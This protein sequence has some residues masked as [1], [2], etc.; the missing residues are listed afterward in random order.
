MDAVRPLA[1]DLCAQTGTRCVDLLVS[2]ATNAFAHPYAA[3]EASAAT[4]ASD[5][6]RLT[7]TAG[8]AY[9]AL[10][11][12]VP[13]VRVLIA[14]KCVSKALD[15]TPGLD[16]EAVGGQ[17]RAFL[18]GDGFGREAPIDVSFFKLQ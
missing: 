13:D 16:A 3:K 14:S 15:R 1:V 18:V 10:F 17:V 6:A 8:R 11:D 2:D 7:T 5:W 9:L 4:A 12:G